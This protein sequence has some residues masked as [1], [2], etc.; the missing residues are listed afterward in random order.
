MVLKPPLNNA[1]TERKKMKSPKDHIIFALDVPSYEEAKKFILLLS[2]R[3]GMFKVG[4]ELFIRT[5]PDI[6]HFIKKE[7]AAGIFLD[8]KL[9]DIPATVSRAMA[10]IANLEVDLTTVHCGE[11]M[12]MLKAA[13]E[14]SKGKTGVLGVTLLTSVSEANIRETGYK[15]EFVSDPSRLVMKKAAMANDAGCRGVVCSGLEVETIKE[16]FGKDFE[17][18]VPGIRPSGGDV[19]QDDQKRIATPGRAIENGADFLVIGR[20]I[21]NAKDPVAVVLAIE[22]EIKAALPLNIN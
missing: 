21:R 19:G 14:G 15:E 11:S 2:G 12:D 6:I 20:P 3:V 8:L 7:G 22:E 4:L 17:G 13:V 16:T 18:V 1:N 10:S 9:H 5:G